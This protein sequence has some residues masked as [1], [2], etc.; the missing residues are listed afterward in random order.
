MSDAVFQFKVGKYECAAVTDGY[1]VV[2][3]PPP[4]GGSGKP[5]MQ[6]GQKM[7]VI[8]LLIDTGS[9]KILIDSGCGDAF[10]STTGQLLQ[11]LKE[12]GIRPADIDVVIYTHGHMDHVAGSF[13]K[14]GQCVFSRA[15]FMAARR[16]FEWWKTGKERAQLQPMFAAA[17]K[18]C[19]TM[20]ERFDLIE[21]NAEA[22]PGIR[23]MLAP[24]HTPGNSI[25]EI[26][27]DGQRLLCIGDLAHSQIEFTRPDFYSFLDVDPEEAIR[28]RNQVLTQAA[29]SGILVLA[30]HF[31]FPGLGHIKMENGLITWQPIS[32]D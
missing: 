5:D 29:G 18:N 25:L 9:K 17:R 27:S 21:D 8:S 11:N 1:L 32:K 2:P 14:Q 28:S 30:S 23:L 13:D 19:L 22:L 3:G 26:S 20:P 24:G 16:E 15:R 7:D 12:A 6:H 4:A 31:P 10:Q